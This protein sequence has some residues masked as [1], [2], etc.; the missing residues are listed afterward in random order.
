[1]RLWWWRR[2]RVAAIPKT[3][4]DS[5]ERFGEAV[6]VG[7]LTSG[8]NPP[9]PELR[10]LYVN[11]ELHQHALKWLTERGD[12]HEQREQRLET[13]EWAILIFVILGVIADFSL[14]FGW[15]NSK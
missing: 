15:F 1:M 7:V 12:Y 5:F 8:L 3:V 6:V 4:R 10:E 11:G 2:V 9:V 14:A 13:V